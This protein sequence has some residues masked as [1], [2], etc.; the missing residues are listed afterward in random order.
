M[1]YDVRLYIPPPIRCFKCQKQRQYVT[2]SNYVGDVLGKMNMGN[3]KR[4]LNL[5]AAI[6]E[7]STAQL[8]EASEETEEVQKVKTTEG[9]TYAEAAKKVKMQPGKTESKLTGAES[10]KSNHCEGYS[11]V[12]KDTD[13]G[14]KGDSFYLR[15]LS[16]L[17][18]QRARQRRSR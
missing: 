1:S 6:V 3:V 5:N 16:A 15:L 2:G 4:E 8:T 13:C 7:E 18:K 14:E 12:E 11:K 10:N 17:C 9:F